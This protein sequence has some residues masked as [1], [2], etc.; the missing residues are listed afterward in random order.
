MSDDLSAR[1]AGLHE[2]PP[3]DQVRRL[4]NELP[5]I[6]RRMLIARIIDMDFV[7]PGRGPAAERVTVCPAGTAPRLVPRAGDRGHINL[8]IKPRRGWINP[9]SV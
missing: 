7:S 8:P 5:I 2:L 9:A 1:D 4:L 3:V 6:E